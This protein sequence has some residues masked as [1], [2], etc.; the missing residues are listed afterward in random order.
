MRKVLHKFL[1][2]DIA[3][4]RLGAF[5]LEISDETLESQIGKS[6]V[7]PADDIPGI[8]KFIQACL[9]LDPAT[10]PSP[11]DLFRGEWVQSGVGG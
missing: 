2:P 1:D 5:K 4:S 11:D 3:Y 7:V 6:G 9:T 10:R 8:V